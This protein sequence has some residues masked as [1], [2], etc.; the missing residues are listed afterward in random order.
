MFKNQNSLEIFHSFPARCFWKCSSPAWILQG[1]KVTLSSQLQV[2]VLRNGARVLTL[3][4]STSCH[5]SCLFSLCKRWTFWD[6]GTALPPPTELWLGFLGKREKPA[7]SPDPGPCLTMGG[8]V[9]QDSQLSQLCPRGVSTGPLRVKA[10]KAWW[11]PRHADT[12]LEAA[13]GVRLWDHFSPSAP[14]SHIKTQDPCLTCQGALPDQAIFVRW[15]ASQVWCCFYC[16]FWSWK[17]MSDFL[18]CKMGVKSLKVK[19]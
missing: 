10:G 2:P 1:S 8:S 13:M 3:M 19:R 17:Q 11:P 9:L 16:C 14:G 7:C 18:F 4:K 15:S 5:P 12:A 6:L